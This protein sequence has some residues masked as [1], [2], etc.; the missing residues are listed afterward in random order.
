MFR[1]GSNIQMGIRVA[2]YQSLPFTFNCLLLIIRYDSTD[3][4]ICYYRRLCVRIHTGPGGSFRDP[5]RKIMIRRKRF[6]LVGNVL[7]LPN[8]VLIFAY[9]DTLFDG[10]S[11]DVGITPDGILAVD[12]LPAE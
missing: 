12:V 5:A 8:L 11:I 3:I 2:R 4:K 9:C 10:R 1:I 7:I 6:L